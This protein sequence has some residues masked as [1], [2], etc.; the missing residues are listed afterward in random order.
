MGLSEPPPVHKPCGDC[1]CGRER[2]PSPQVHEQAQ[3]RDAISPSP[4]VRRCMGISISPF[5]SY[6]FLQFY[7]KG[8]DTNSRPPERAYRRCV[9][10]EESSNSP[11][12]SLPQGEHP[13]P[14]LRAQCWELLSRGQ[15]LFLL[16]KERK[17]T[18]LHHFASITICR[19]VSFRDKEKNL[20]SL[21]GK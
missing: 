7:T 18:T 1:F 10:G 8:L 20:D 12:H 11:L 17:D 19:I 6:N 13:Q 15:K 16:E 4:P 5:C 9:R 14:T 3:V 2:A 21:P